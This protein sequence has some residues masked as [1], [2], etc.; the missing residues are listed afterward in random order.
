VELTCGGV[1]LPFGVAKDV[2]TLHALQAIPNAHKITR[3]N[4]IS[5]NIGRT[6]N[7]VVFDARENNRRSE[8]QFAP[9]AEKVSQ[10]GNFLCSRR[11]DPLERDIKIEREV[12][13]HIVMRLVTA[14]RR[15]CLGSQSHIA[16]RLV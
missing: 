10:S 1:A 13:H 5:E 8:L 14:S 4:F 3:K 15:Q 9:A 12:R 11:K 16:R 7:S 6:F 2:C